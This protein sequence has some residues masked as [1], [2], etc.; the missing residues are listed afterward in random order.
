MIQVFHFQFWQGACVQLVFQ[1]CLRLKSIFTLSRG[2]KSFF[3]LHLGGFRLIQFFVWPLGS[4]LFILGCQ[5]YLVLSQ[6]LKPIFDFVQGI[7]IRPI[8]VL[9]L[10]PRPILVFLRELGLS[11]FALGSPLF[12]QGPLGPP[13]SLFAPQV[14]PSL[15]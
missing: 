7:G 10:G 8:I 9:I 2:I 5:T 11:W 12:V 3:F 13:C 1:F 14:H 15:S 6:G 4:F